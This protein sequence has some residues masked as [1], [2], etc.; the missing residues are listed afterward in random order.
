M[1]DQVVEI[2]SETDR[3]SKHFPNLIK[4]TQVIACG[5]SGHKNAATMHINSHKKNNRREVCHT[6]CD[7]S[8]HWLFDV[9]TQRSSFDSSP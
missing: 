7:N 9:P 5:N 2:K 6:H 4:L 8:L 1:S 3:I